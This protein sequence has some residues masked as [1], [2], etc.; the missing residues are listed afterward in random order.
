MGNSRFTDQAPMGDPNPRRSVQHNGKFS[1]PRFRRNQ[2]CTKNNQ[3]RKSKYKLVNFFK[4][5]LLLLLGFAPKASGNTVS[6][7]SASSSGTVINNEYQTINGGFPTMIYGG[8]VQC[9]QPTLAFTPFITKGENYSTPRITSTETNIYDLAENETGDLIN[10]GKIL[11]TQIQPRIDQSTHNFNYG[12]TISL[13]VPLGKG[14]DLCIKAAENQIAGQE[15]V[16]TKQKLEANLARM[17]ICA[18]QFK[19]GVKLINED[20]VACKNVVLTTIPNQVLPHTH[21]LKQ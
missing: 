13:Q 18:E 3:Y 20:A 1:C 9:Q 5:S 4:L 10:P 16:L 2:H 17:K 7:P 15:F 19:L 14:S 12:F 6:S 11:Y 8:Q 21:K